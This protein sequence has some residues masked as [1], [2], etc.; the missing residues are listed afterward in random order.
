MRFWTHLNRNLPN[1]CHVNVN[2]CPTRCDYI[3]FYYISANSCTCFEWYLLTSSGAHT[4]CNYSIWNWSN[5]IAAVR[6]CGGVMSLAS[7]GRLLATFNSSCV[8]KKFPPFDGTRRFITVSKIVRH[9]SWTILTQRPPI[10]FFLTSFCSIIVPF[11][12]RSLMWLL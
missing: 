9:L 4:D 10:Q 7:W 12:S 1:I 8:F 3:Q 2:N 6:C 5:R 11:V